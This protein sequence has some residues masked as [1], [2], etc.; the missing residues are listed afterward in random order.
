MP[1]ASIA[2]DQP[3]RPCRR[4]TR[5]PAI[6]APVNAIA[7]VVESIF[8]AIASAIQP[9]LDAV[10]P[11]VHA[12]GSLFMTARREPVGALVQALVDA[13]ATVVEAFIDALATL[14]ESLVDTITAIL[15]QHRGC[16]QQGQ[17]A[18][19]QYGCGFHDSLLCN[20][21]KNS[22]PTLSITPG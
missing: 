8:D 21:L 22:G 14:V 10:T 5:L 13:F 11:V 2:T 1:H 19:G 6:N 7:A 18:A 17:Q 4:S 15:G 20:G 3:A 16:D 9:V 12:P